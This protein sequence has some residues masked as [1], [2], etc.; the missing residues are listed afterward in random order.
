MTIKMI[1][2]LS[3]VGVTVSGPLEN[4]PLCYAILR[5]AEECVK[6][7]PKNKV[8]NPSGIVPNMSG[9]VRSN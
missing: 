4:K 8:M 9:P 2:E 5:G 7:Y 6:E 1:I 3:D